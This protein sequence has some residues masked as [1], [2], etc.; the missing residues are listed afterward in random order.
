MR[1]QLILSMVLAV[2]APLAF[3]QVDSAT[4]TTNEGSGVITVFTPGNVIVLKEASGPR[5]YRFGKSVTYETKSGQV[6]SEDEVRTRVKVGV[7]VHVHYTEEG[8]EMVVDR[9]ILDED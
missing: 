9:V 8:D 3:A 2:A 5:S 6:I 4:T 1:K 7:P